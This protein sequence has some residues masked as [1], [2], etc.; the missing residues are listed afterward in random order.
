MEVT[1]TLRRKK[2]NGLSHQSLPLVRPLE[3]L[4]H[5]VVVI[6]DKGQDPGLQVLNREKRATFEQL[7]NQDAEPDFNLIEKG[8]YAWGYNET[9]P[10]GSAHSKRPHGWA[11]RPI[12][13]FCL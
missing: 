1:S 2:S 7:T 10:D 13:R 6:R 11:W 3:R 8:N 4:S 9:P 12:D 5:R